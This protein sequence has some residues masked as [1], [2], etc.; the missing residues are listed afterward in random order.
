MATQLEPM[1]VSA[2]EA[3]R[4]LGVSKPKV[5]ELMGRED[6]PAFKLGGRTLISVEGLR[7]WVKAQAEKGEI[8][9]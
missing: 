2:V 7:A 5:Y 8:S 1:A 3:A 9:Q 6:F 4:L